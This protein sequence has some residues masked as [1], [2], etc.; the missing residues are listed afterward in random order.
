[1]RINII[2][3]GDEDR[4]FEM[5]KIFVKRIGEDPGNCREYY[6]NIRTEQRYCTVEGEFHTCTDEGEPL[7]PF[8]KDIEIRIMP[9]SCSGFNWYHADP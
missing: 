8:R 6:E 2:H 9:P 4:G 7:A 1:V 3:L 5:R